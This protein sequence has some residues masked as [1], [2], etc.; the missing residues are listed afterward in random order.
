MDIAEAMELAETMSSS[1]LTKMLASLKAK[2]KKK[3]DSKKL[4]NHV[5]FNLRINNQLF[6]QTV[7]GED[8]IKH[9]LETLVPDLKIM[10]PYAIKSQIVGMFEMLAEVEELKSLKDK[11]RQR[12]TKVVMIDSQ[13]HLFSYVTSLATGIR[14]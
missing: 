2:K 9:F 5:P 1:Q 7:R 10:P 13:E 11:W 3:E 4:K 14:M 12:A 6:R 8:V